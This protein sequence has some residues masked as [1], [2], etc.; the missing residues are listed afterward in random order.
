MLTGSVYCGQKVCTFYSFRL[1]R[2][3]FKLSHS[4][5]RMMKRITTVDWLLSNALKKII[6]VLTFQNGFMSK[7]GT[8][9]VILSLKMCS[10]ESET[11]WDICK[12]FTA[13]MH[14]FKCTHSRNATKLAM[15]LL[16]SFHLQLQWVESMAERSLEILQLQMKKKTSQN[17]YKVLNSIY[18]SGKKGKVRF[19]YIWNH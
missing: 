6:F 10:T 7:L 3:R 1:I 9:D 13:P 15:H 8:F 18:A 14:L 19:V 4:K 2:F 17:I 16:Q 5:T 12:V 11:K